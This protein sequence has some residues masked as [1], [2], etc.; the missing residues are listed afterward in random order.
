MIMM[1]MLVDLC[2]YVPGEKNQNWS[3]GN[4][5]NVALEALLRLAFSV[6][7]SFFTNLKQI[8]APHHSCCDLLGRICDRTSHLLSDLHGQLILTIVEQF[9]SLLHNFLPVCK[10]GTAIGLERELGILGDGL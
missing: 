6:L 2:T 8:F 1:N 4:L 10:T 7:E 3:N 9:Q 5:P